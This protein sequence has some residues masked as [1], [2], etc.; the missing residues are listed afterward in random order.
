MPTHTPILELPHSTGLFDSPRPLLCLECP[1]PCVLYLVASCMSLTTTTP[2]LGRHVLSQLAQAQCFPWAQ[3][4][5]VVACL[6]VH[7][8]PVYLQ[9]PLRA[10][11]PEHTRSVWALQPAGRR[12]W[13]ERHQGWA[14][15]R[16]LTSPPPIPPPAGCCESSLRGTR[17]QPEPQ[18][19]SGANQTWDSDLALSETPPLSNPVL[20]V[21]PG[22]A[23][24]KSIRMV[25]CITTG[26]ML[27][28]EGCTH[29]F[30][31]DCIR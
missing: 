13:E 24:N 6:L 4:P 7:E 29:L 18:G 1:L 16:H 10:A 19:W 30:E 22:M 27:P 21:H 8:L 15:C 14:F 11:S 28:Q 2:R 12:R 17:H 23:D 9:G 3:F 26:H 25:P 5:A 20:T 31:R